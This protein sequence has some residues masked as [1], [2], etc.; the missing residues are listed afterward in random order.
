[1]N[2]RERSYRY[3]RFAAFGSA[4]SLILAPIAFERSGAGSDAR[5]RAIYQGSM[6]PPHPYMG[7]SLN[8]MHEDAYNTDVSKS[9][10]PLGRN[11]KWEY[12]KIDD[13]PA[14]CPTFVVDSRGRLITI[15]I[16]KK[17]VELRRIDPSSLR[18]IH[19]VALPAPS[20]RKRFKRAFKFLADPD[21]VF[22]NVSG[23]PY[24]Y[25]DNRDRI[26]VP[27]VNDQIRIYE[28]QETSKGPRFAEV[29]RLPL[30]KSN[31]RPQGI[32]DGDGIV[33]V[34]PD[35]LRP[36]ML[37]FV[38]ADGVV[39]LVHART[40]TLRSYRLKPGEDI[41]N[42][43]AVCMEG[44]FVLS[45]RALYRFRIG[46][47]NAPEKVWEAPYA[48]CDT[49]DARGKHHTKDKPGQLGCGSGTTPTLFGD[50]LVAVGDLAKPHMNVVV[51]N[52]ATGQLVGAHPIFTPA[53]GHHQPGRS[54]S[55]NSF[56]AYGNS[57]IVCNTYGYTSPFN[58]NKQID[59]GLVRVDVNPEAA[60]GERL[61]TVWCTPFRIWSTTPK[62]S[63][64]NRIIYTYTFLPN[65]RAWYAIGIR[66]L[67]GR[68]AFRVKVSA[69]NKDKPSGILPKRYEYDQFDNSWGPVFLGPGP[70]GRPAM[71]VGMVRGFLRLVD[72]G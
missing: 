15:A 62:L 16:T 17:D 50:D 35:W 28:Q 10:G 33:G 8:S 13:K 1:M 18:T 70:R 30:S 46:G 51:Y 65:E 63:R 59:G 34:L 47:G 56:I 20:K 6:A 25:V 36:D 38:S 58:D 43:L 14:M 9:H 64:E 31:S 49:Y 12:V 71:Y 42:S 61:K 55:E 19:K 41:R 72:E 11:T 48:T 67:D 68:E 27:T 40:G 26:V 45:S 57:L 5:S 54:H 39:G 4:V 21:S 66:Y 52:R 53:D 44:A 29:A 37:W 60:P 24:L 7:R 23:G 3:L 22:E 2:R 32:G 69:P